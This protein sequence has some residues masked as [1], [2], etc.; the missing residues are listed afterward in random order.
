MWYIHLMHVKQKISFLL[1]GLCIGALL[2]MSTIGGAL[3][4]S[5]MMADGGMTHCPYMGVTALCG[6]TPLEH[7]AQWQHIFLATAQQLASLALLLSITVIVW[8]FTANIFVTREHYFAVYR[9]RYRQK[10]FDPLRLAFA[11]GILH[12]KVY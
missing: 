1:F 12:T 5:M 4:A 6:M 8:H 10:H 11:R 3:S 9:K 2:F 7:L